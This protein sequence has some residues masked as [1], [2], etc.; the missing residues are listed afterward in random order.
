MWAECASHWVQMKQHIEAQKFWHIQEHIAV[1]QVCGND[2]EFIMH[3]PNYY[4]YMIRSKKKK[5]LGSKLPNP[6]QRGPYHAL[7]R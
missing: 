7:V 3:Q 6:P 5:A 2:E 1:L 4:G